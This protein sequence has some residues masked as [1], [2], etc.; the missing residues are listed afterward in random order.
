MTAIL[1]ILSRNR[2]LR[3][4]F[5]A[6]FLIAFHY[7]LIIYI[8]S[9]LLT[10]FFSA[11]AVSLIFVLGSV[12]NLILLLEA[13]WLI[14]RTGV[15]F[16]LILW[17][18]AEL[19]A[20][21]LLAVSSIPWLVAGAFIVHQGV[22]MMIVFALDILLETVI[23]KETN[24]GLIRG[25]YL[26]VANGSL[27]VAPL[28]VSLIV[29]GENYRPLYLLSSILLI[30]FF[31]LAFSSLRQIES[32]QEETS[33]PETIR[34]I[35]SHPNI[36]RVSMA[37]LT[38]QFF[39]AWMVIYTPIYLH[40]VVGFSWQTI[41]Q[42]FTVMLLPFIMLGIPVGRLADRKL[43]E[44][45]MMFAGFIIMALASFLI[46][47][48]KVAAVLPWMI[49]LFF[50]RIGASLTETTNESYFFKQVKGKDAHIVSFFRLMRPIAFI[51]A[52]ALAWLSLSTFGLREMFYLLALVTA[53]G[54]WYTARLRDTR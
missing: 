42:I 45:E 35:T 33:I 49:L 10:R 29:A 41:G 53:S 51:L 30:P 52:P 34:Q 25:G 26:T 48:L 16:T 32:Y 54:L 8:N 15:F 4:I 38:L 17:S 43:G 50:S 24:T 23:K 1:S 2:H 44:K 9:S 20:V 11:S 40:G 47:S 46:P 36:M 22:V 39:Y 13:P 19:V 31:L 3:A 5:L 14:R 27:V 18:A 37:Q 21:W 12:L 28:L 7:F 6:N